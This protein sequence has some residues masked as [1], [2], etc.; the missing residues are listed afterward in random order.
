MLKYPVKLCRK[1]RR[2]FTECFNVNIT[3]PN[4][5]QAPWCWLKPEIC[6]SFIYVYFNVNFN[7]FFKWIK[8]HLLVSELHI[9]LYIFMSFQTK[10]WRHQHEECRLK[11]LN[12]F[13]IKIK[14]IKI[15]IVPLASDRKHSVFVSECTYR[16]KMQSS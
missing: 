14:K 16:W 2:N 10:F 3:L 8:V 11:F 15:P 7:A 12:I 9:Y 1:L 13:M 4:S 6:R 5:V